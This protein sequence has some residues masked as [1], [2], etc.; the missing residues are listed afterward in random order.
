M[1]F[2]YYYCTSHIQASSILIFKAHFSQ[3]C[4]VLLHIQ[5]FSLF[6]LSFHSLFSLFFS[7]ANNNVPLP[8]WPILHRSPVTLAHLLGLLWRPQFILQNVEHTVKSPPHITW[9]PQQ[10]FHFWAPVGF[11]E[12][13][14]QVFISRYQ[15][16]VNAD[17]HLNMNAQR[18]S[19]AW[20]FMTER[21]LHGKDKLMQALPTDSERQFGQ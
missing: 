2:L 4:S 14:N 12:Q 20:R 7:L 16:K 21:V 3:I 1:I 10:T 13:H 15:T 19:P 18:T 9:K 11:T 8:F 5:H 17:Q 6:C